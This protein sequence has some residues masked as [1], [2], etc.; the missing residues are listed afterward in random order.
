MSEAFPR[1]TVLGIL[2]LTAMATAVGLEA[3]RQAEGLGSVLGQPFVVPWLLL[4]PGYLACS[5]LTVDVEFRD[6]TRLVVL[7][8]LPL[9]LGVVF[10]APWLHLAARAIARLLELLFVRRQPLVKK[11]FNT[12]LAVLEVGIA[13][14]TW[15]ALGPGTEPG[16]RMWL[17]LLAAL[18]VSDLASYAVMGVLFALLGIEMDARERW[19]SLGT[20]ALTTAL[21]GCVAV[22]SVSAMWTDP[23]VAAVILLLAGGLS[24]G[25]RGHRRLV[26]RHRTTEQLYELVKEL[27]PLDLDRPQARLA[28]DAVRDLL[29]AGE[30]DLAVCEPGTGSWR[31]LV[32]VEPDRRPPPADRRPDAP[33]RLPALAERVAATGAPVLQHRRGGSRDRMAT[34]LVG[35]GGLLGVLTV[36]DRLGTTRG[37]DM[38]DLRLLEAVSAALGKI[39]RAHV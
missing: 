13:E 24:L 27:G 10:V 11:L 39:G 15:T 20:S 3:V 17:T 16:V 28:V 9:A 21:F 6:Q 14:L 30:L 33:D 26:S 5:R 4:V 25:Y 23:A 31:H 8:Q 34:P 22:V 12:G 36:T 35:G 37:F 7:T 1:R 18:L 19:N 32:S 29:H 38:Q 2:L